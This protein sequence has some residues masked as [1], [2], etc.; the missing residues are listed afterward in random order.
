MAKHS[1]LQ[2]NDQAG[3]RLDHFLTEQFPDNTRSYWTKMIKHGYVQLNGSTPK[4]GQKLSVGDQVDLELPEVDT[5]FEGRVGLIF[6]SDDVMVMNKP[7]GMLA[8]SK[9][10]FNPEYTIADF[11][12]PNVDFVE[13]GQNNRAGIV[14]RLDRYTS[15]VIIAAKNK[16]AMEELQTQFANRQTQKFYLGITSGLLSEDKYLLEGKIGRSTSNPKS[17]TVTETGK[18]ATTKVYV[19]DR[20]EAADQ[21]YVLLQPQTGRTH[22]LR[23]HLA[24]LGY[25]LLGDTLYRGQGDK[26]SGRFMLHAYQLSLKQPGQAVISNF[27]A[28]LPDDMSSY[29]DHDR[30]KSVT[31]L[32]ESITS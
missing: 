9:G 30:L 10:A 16:V 20:D 31:K 1:K 12:A 32:I 28:E 19:V 5:S 17:M 8:H 27:V 15:G 2:I 26:D 7:A 18:P 3:Q 11:I 29:N 25:P 4:A 23:V 22:Q 13:K 6:E 21:T 24:E 14:H